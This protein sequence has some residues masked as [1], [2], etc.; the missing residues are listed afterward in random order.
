[1]CGEEDRGFP[2]SHTSLCDPSGGYT[3]KSCLCPS[4]KS[5]GLGLG[6]SRDE[7][8]ST[9]WKL[10]TQA[11]S[12]GALT[13]ALLD[14]CCLC[15]PAGG[16]DCELGERGKSLSVGQR[17]LVCLAR[18]LLTQA[19]VSPANSNWILPSQSRE[20]SSLARGCLFLIVGLVEQDREALVRE[21]TV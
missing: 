3:H 21:W 16:L 17:Q 4:L 7:V 8:L 13:K 10:L 5:Q 2:V 14:E 6:L 15:L 12:A 1:M 11:C 20:V 9:S 18:A 19:K